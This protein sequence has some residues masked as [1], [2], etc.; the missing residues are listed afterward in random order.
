MFGVDKKPVEKEI[1]KAPEPIIEEKKPIIE[2]KPVIKEAEAP[3]EKPEPVQK[4]EPVTKPAKVVEF[5]DGLSSGGRGPKMVWIPAGAF[6]MGSPDSSNRVDER[7]RHEVTI[8][9]FAISKYEITFAEYDRYAAAAGKRRPRSHG[10]DRKTTPVTGVNWDEAAGYAK[11]LARQTGKKYRLASESEWEYAA[12]GGQVSPYWWGF[13]EKPGMAHCFACE[14]PFN[15]TQPAKVGSFKPN[16]F[17]VHDTAGNV[18][19]WVADCWHPS[20]NNAPT[21]GSVWTGGDC[22]THVVRGGSFNSPP[23]SI[24]R[25]SRDKLSTVSRYEHVGIRVVREQ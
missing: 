5:S 10:M 17:G 14:S 20:Y 22:K 13:D 21:N 25:T 9:K 2:E 23:L 16:Q 24:R 7:P 8:K 6:Q 4:T 1:V 11:W 19:E 3:V 15:P 18:A 12:S